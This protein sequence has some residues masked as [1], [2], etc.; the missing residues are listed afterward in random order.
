MT[1][2]PEEKSKKE[3][4]SK[5]KK[6]GFKL[7]LVM[8]IAGCLAPFGIPTLL[9]CLGL[10]P[11]FVA[12]VTDTDE[13]RSG[14]ATIGYMNFAGV[15]PFLIDL[16]Q[17]GQTMDAAMAIIRQPASWAIMLGA[18]GIGHLILYAVPP[19]IASVFLINQES[20]L[21]TLREGM[22]QLE[23]IWGPDVASDTSLDVVKSN[24]GG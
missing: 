6:G 5:P 19:V 12:L 8:V 13:N 4:G 18:A 11:T 7:I 10:T 22:Q 1:G 15:L 3:K 21:R 9:I 24:R 20:R 16:W 14:L 17:N 23:A 2:A